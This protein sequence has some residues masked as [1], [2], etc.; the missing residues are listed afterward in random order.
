MRRGNPS[1]VACQGE[2]WS[3]F[4]QKCTS[5][6]QTDPQT[7]QD[8]DTRHTQLVPVGVN[9]QVRTIT[10]NNMHKLIQQQNALG[11]RQLF[12]GRMSTEWARI[13]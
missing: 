1:A 8:S 12:N 10:P 6:L 7:V 11:W 9:L 3:A 13:H 2:Y 5:S 4:E